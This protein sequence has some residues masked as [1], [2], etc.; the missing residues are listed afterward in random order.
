MNLSII[1]ANYS[2][3]SPIY[4]YMSRI[5]PSMMSISYIFSMQF[6]EAQTQ[7]YVEQPMSSGDEYFHAQNT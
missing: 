6:A 3:I 7:S 2:A 4:D 5:M 1:D